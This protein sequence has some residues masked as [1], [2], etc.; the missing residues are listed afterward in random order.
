MAETYLVNTTTEILQKLSSIASKGKILPLS[1]VK[2]DFKSIERKLCT[3]QALISDALHR[4]DDKFLILWLEKIKCVVCDTTD[5]L[6]EFLYE[7]H[8][9]EIHYSTGNKVHVTNFFVASNLLRVFSDKTCGINQRLIDVSNDDSD[10]VI[11]RESDRSKVVEMLLKVNSLDER[12][13]VIP[14][15]GGA[16]IGKT[17]LARLVYD[18]ES[19]KQHFKSRMVDLL[20]GELQENLSGKKYLLVLDDVQ[21]KDLE[22]L[23]GFES[24]GKFPA[25]KLQKL[26]EDECWSLFKQRAFWSAV[27]EKEI[28]NLVGIGKDIAR[29]C[30]GSPMAAKTL[31]GLMHSKKEEH[32]WFCQR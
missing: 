31:G 23:F 10:I 18:D 24:V 6:D 4:Q 29:K 32:E 14:I 3:I 13:S 20:I 1:D 28:P 15:V 7:A 8:R 12:V 16:G 25:Y 19:V 30:D 21:D 5:V 26:T 2:E 27:G 11:G 17:T 9:C 22:K